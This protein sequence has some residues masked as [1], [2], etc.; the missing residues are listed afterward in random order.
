MPNFKLLLAQ[1]GVILITARL[2]G[3]LF[4]RLHQPRVIGEMIAGILLGPSLLGW[5]A[6]GVS[7][8]LFAPDSLGALGALSQTGLL[9]FMFVVGLELDVRQLRAL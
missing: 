7:A 4:R 6:P 3:W 2:V 9:L 8:T 1:I 5:V